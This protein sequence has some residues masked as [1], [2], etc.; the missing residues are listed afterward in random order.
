MRGF[1]LLSGYGGALVYFSLKIWA[2]GGKVKICKD[3]KIGNIYYNEGDKKP[4]SMNLEDY[5]YN[6]IITAFIL[7]DWDTAIE[8]LYKHDNE[9]IE[10]IKNRILKNMPEIMAMREYISKNKKQDINHLIIK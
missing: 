2:I 7:L 6:R 5:F 3:V 10:I 4:W 8:C 9:Y 1:S